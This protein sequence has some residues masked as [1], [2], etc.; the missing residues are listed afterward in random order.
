MF[1]HLVTPSRTKIAQSTADLITYA[2][3]PDGEVIAVLKE[4]TDQP[5]T[6]ILRRLP[7][8]EQYEI[9]HDVLAQHIL[10]W[11]RRY[12]SRKEEA[13]RAKEQAEEAARKQR[14]L[15]QA[16]ALAK[17]QSLR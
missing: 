15:E 6:R 7:N 1:V 9:F 12:D 13:E 5:R 2:E 10:D 3:A 14:E 11:R 17:E 16:Q 4:L 8:P